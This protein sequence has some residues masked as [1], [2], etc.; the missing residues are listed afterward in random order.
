M[1][2]AGLLLMSIVVMMRWPGTPAARTIHRWLVEAPARH[3]ARVERVHLI[4]ALLLVGFL[5]V[6]GELMALFGPHVA[7]GFVVDLALYLDVATAAA[8]IAVVA[9]GRSAALMLRAWCVA[10]STPREPSRPRQRRTRTPRLTRSSDDSD[11]RWAPALA[12]A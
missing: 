4:V 10:V 7:F 3:L 9:K 1:T 8:T 6:G 2:L 12:F 5:F 11:R